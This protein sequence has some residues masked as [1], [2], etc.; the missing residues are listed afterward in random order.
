MYNIEIAYSKF[1]NN[2][3]ARYTVA[4]TFIELKDGL[5]S[6]AAVARCGR[7]DQFCKAKGR[8]IALSRLNKLLNALRDKNHF[9]E[10]YQIQCLI[11]DNKLVKHCVLIPAQDN[12][13]FDLD[14]TIHVWR[15]IH[16]N[17]L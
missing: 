8:Q 3:S 6:I 17:G 10:L 15:N 11:V 16:K 13:V 14:R 4:Y 5:W 1:K 7:K 2:K 9:D 12:E